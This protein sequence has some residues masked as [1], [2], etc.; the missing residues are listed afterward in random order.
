MAPETKQYRE[1]EDEGHAFREVEDEGHALDILSNVSDLRK[2]EHLFDVTLTSGNLRVPCHRIVLAGASKYFRALFTSRMREYGASEV[3]VSEVPPGVLSVVV[4]FVYMGR[5]RITRANVQEVLVACNFLEVLR[6]RELCED[7]L[8]DA[9]SPATSVGY[10]A[11]AEFY[12]LSRLSRLARQAMLTDFTA[13]VREP[14]Y[15]EMSADDLAAY[16]ARRHAV[17]G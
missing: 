11:F 9:L 10:W 16:I 2:E 8:V 6:L 15:L 5:A 13:V 3:Q 17:P 1:L 7:F 14:E 12:S 4:D